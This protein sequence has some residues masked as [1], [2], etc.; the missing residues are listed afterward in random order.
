MMS[1]RGTPQQPPTS[2]KKPVC[3]RAAA[4]AAAAALL[5]LAS[6]C[7]GDATGPGERL[8]PLVPDLEPFY[9]FDGDKISLRITPDTFSVLAPGADA[10]EVASDV[11]SG[12]NL[13]VRVV[14]DLAEGHRLLE[15]PGA[16]RERAPALSDRLWN[17]PAITF[18]APVYRVAE[19]GSSAGAWFVPLNTVMVQFRPDVGEDA[20]REL[21]GRLGTVVERAPELEEGWHVLRLPDDVVNGRDALDIASIYDRH[22]LTEWADLNNITDISLYDVSR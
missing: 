6:A 12:R 17:H 20:V 22:E 5:V 3:G 11:L 9:W 21:S 18:A 10:E 1:R 16:G 7:G 13:E 2:G 8:G 19:E 4:S 15:V 14:D